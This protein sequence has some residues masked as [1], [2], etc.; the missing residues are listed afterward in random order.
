MSIIHIGESHYAPE[1]D[2]E[3]ACE[4]LSTS[5]APD[6]LVLKFHSDMPLFGIKDRG[7]NW[8]EESRKA[9]DTVRWGEVYG[10]T[11]AIPCRELEDHGMGSVPAFADETT[12]KFIIV[13]EEGSPECPCRVRIMDL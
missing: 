2:E 7:I 5:E 10:W 1:I 11:Y 3:K 4:S 8:L 6:L 13:W 9:Y 12:K